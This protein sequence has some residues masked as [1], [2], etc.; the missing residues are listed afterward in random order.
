[1]QWYGWCERDGSGASETGLIGHPA[2]GAFFF[3]APKLA[4]FQEFAEEHC[5]DLNEEP[6]KAII[7][8]FQK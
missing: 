3:W 7:D 2:D 4:R 6:E 5:W 8:H 1:V